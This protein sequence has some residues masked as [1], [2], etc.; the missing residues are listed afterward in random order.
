MSYQP[1]PIDTTGVELPA[2]II[3]LRELLA[4]NAHDLWARD[5][6]KQGWQYGPQRDDAKKHNP[7]LVPY[8]ELPDTEKQYDRNNAMETLKAI[9]KLGYRIEKKD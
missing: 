7:C 3:D 2:A 8:E 9:M 6:L 5:R 1:K 4:K